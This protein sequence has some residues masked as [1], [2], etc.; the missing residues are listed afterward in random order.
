MKNSDGKTHPVG[1]KKP[2]GFGLYDMSGNVIEWCWDLIDCE[3]RDKSDGD[4]SLLEG[5]E[6]PAATRVNPQS[7]LEGFYRVARGGCLFYDSAR[8]RVSFRCIEIEDDSNDPHGIACGAGF[9][10]AR[11]IL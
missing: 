10:I 6:Y 5:T 4:I 2:N 9:R 8:V 7:P 1:Q 11:S 3:V